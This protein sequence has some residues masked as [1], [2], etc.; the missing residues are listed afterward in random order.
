MNKKSP[1]VSFVVNCFNGELFLKTC[2]NSILSQ[3]YTN[4][5]LIFWDNVIYKYY[6][7]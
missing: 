7:R 6:K 1:L 5:E 4:W 2:L 3:T